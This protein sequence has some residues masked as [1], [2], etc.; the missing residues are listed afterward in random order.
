MPMRRFGIHLE[1]IAAE[2]GRFP[3]GAYA[4]SLMQLSLVAGL[5]GNAEM[6]RRSGIVVSS[7]QSMR[8]DAG[9]MVPVRTS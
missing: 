7:E 8:D 3:Q 4:R 6:C 1:D 5:L 9:S 2:S